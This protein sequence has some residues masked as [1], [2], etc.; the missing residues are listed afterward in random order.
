MNYSPEKL[1]YYWD[2][3]RAEYIRQVSAEDLDAWI[4]LWQRLGQKIE[5]IGALTAQR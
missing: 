2:I 5:A 1:C 3:E 4:A